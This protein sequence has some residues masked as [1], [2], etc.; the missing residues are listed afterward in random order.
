MEFRERLDAVGDVEMTVGNRVLPRRTADL[1][2]LRGKRDYHL[3]HPPERDGVAGCNVEHSVTAAVQHRAHQHGDVIDMHVVAHLFPFAEERDRLA[4]G[5]KPAETVRAITVVRILRAIDQRRPQNGE[6]QLE[7]CSQ[8]DLARE[9]HH[10]MQA[11]WLLTGPLGHRVGIVGIDRIGTDVDKLRQLPSSN[12]G[13]YCFRHAQIVDEHRVVARRRKRGDKY[14]DVA[15]SQ[16]ALQLRRGFG[17]EQ[18]DVLAGE[19]KVRDLFGGKARADRVADEPAST[20]DHDTTQRLG[21]LSRMF[22]HA[23][24]PWRGVGALRG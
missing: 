20:H 1:S 7:R 11:R 10:A 2:R 9:M 15:W 3:G 4:L 17:L 12:R 18:V 13:A 6:R 16:H 19:R 8:H 21:P 14:H 5:G 24:A 23:E 22:K